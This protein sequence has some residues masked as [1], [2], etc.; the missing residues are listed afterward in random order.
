MLECFHRQRWP[1][2]T[3]LWGSAALFDIQF[4]SAQWSQHMVCGPEGVLSQ[5]VECAFESHSSTS[6]DV[7]DGESRYNY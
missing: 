4:V 3:S 2:G 5:K 7:S 1:S 6:R